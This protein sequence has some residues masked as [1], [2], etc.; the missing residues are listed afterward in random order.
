MTKRWKDDCQRCSFDECEGGREIIPSEL[1]ET[2]HIQ[3]GH[4]LDMLDTGAFRRYAG[5]VFLRC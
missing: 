4:M 1:C 2:L 5:R 3:F